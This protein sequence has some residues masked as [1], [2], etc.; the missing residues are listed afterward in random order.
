MKRTEILVVFGLVTLGSLL[1]SY[2]SNNPSLKSP[3]N[4]IAI[5]SSVVQ[6][7]TFIHW[8][9]IDKDSEKIDKIDFGVE[10][11][12]MNSERVQTEIQQLTKYQTEE[13]KQYLDAEELLG[14]FLKEGVV[15]NEEIIKLIKNSRSKPVFI[16]IGCGGKIKAKVSD[17]ENDY[18]PHIDIL[19]S[20]GF[21]PIYKKGSLLIT[22]K[23]DLLPKYQNLKKIKSLVD[24]VMSEQW[25]KAKEIATQRYPES[26]YPKWYR[27]WRE[28]TS[29][30]YNLTF[31]EVREGSIDPIYRQ[32]TSGETKTCF[33]P[34]FIKLILKTNGRIDLSRIIKRED[35]IKVKEIIKNVSLKH[36]L[37]DID[38]ITKDILE[39]GE[40]Q[41]LKNLNLDSFL[42]ISGISEL[43]L[44]LELKKY[45]PENLAH[46]TSEKVIK[47]ANNYLATLNRIGL[48]M[49]CDGQ[50]SNSGS[51]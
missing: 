15:S 49:G 33:T 12:K 28:G 24:S 40:S 41:I 39:K 47:Q 19:T 30:R 37:K 26:K 6:I 9:F 25:M 22:F 29:Q 10:T 8:A 50:K 16:A 3:L 42:S 2:F 34:E 32:M 35:Y 38:P 4:F 46:E 20:L 36:I 13:K 51:T 48:N 27:G 43:E 7:A 18:Y 14:T 17:K 21:V 11:L 23:E 5:G 44:E 1:L 31:I 45:F